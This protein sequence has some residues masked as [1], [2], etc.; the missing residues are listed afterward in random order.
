MASSRCIEFPSVCSDSL[1]Y[2]SSNGF[3]QSVNGLDGYYLASSKVVSRSVVAVVCPG[4]DFNAAT[5]LLMQLHLT[6]FAR[7]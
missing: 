6:S 3:S 1:R 5:P 2:Q 7:P 4:V